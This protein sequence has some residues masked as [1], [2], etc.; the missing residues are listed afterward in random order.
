MPADVNAA[1]H[2]SLELTA[3]AIVA[4]IMPFIVLWV[5]IQELRGEPCPPTN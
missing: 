1:R 4:A 5:V 3:L 2:W